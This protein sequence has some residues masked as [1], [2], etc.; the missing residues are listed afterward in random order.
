LPKQSPV[1]FWS[2]TSKL[3]RNVGGAKINR[4]RAT[5]RRCQQ[6]SSK[7]LS[8]VHHVFSGTR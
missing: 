6:T 2:A 4:V 7:N 1:I 5:N 8:A 3:F